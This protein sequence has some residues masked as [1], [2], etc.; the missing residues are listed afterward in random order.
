[1]SNVVLAMGL[2]R[3]YFH[4]EGTRYLGERAEVLKIRLVEYFKFLPRDTVI[5]YIR[6]IHQ[7]NDC[8]YL[9]TKSY[10]IV[11]TPDVEILEIFKPYPKFIVNTTRHN[12]FYK[13][14]LESEMLKLGAK[15]VTIVGVET[16]TNVLFTAEELRNM[17]YEVIVPEPLTCSEDDYLHTAG[18]SL[19]SNTLSV[20]VE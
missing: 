16:H 10:A 20:R 19:L 6:E 14:P 2:Q 3:A 11:G 7:T 5:Y 1:M 13:T 15:S 17:G 18:I 12:A 4:S 9:N 8:F